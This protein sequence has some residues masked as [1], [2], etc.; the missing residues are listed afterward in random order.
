[1]VLLPSRVIL[2]SFHFIPDDE[3]LITNGVPKK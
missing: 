1:M 2:F 3:L